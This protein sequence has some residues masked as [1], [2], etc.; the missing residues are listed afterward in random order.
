M[1]FFDR[2]RNFADKVIGRAPRAAEPGIEPEISQAWSDA[3][4]SRER[5]P[6]LFERVR[7]GAK[8][9]FNLG[10]MKEQAPPKV[11]EQKPDI[12]P[13]TPT[14]R[15]FK[16]LDESQRKDEIF[17]FRRNTQ[18]EGHAFYRLT[19]SIWDDPSIPANQRDAA[20]RKYFEEKYGITDMNEIYDLVLDRNKELIE[21]YRNAPNADKYEVLKNIKINSV[22]L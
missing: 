19:Q 18:D 20:I 15:H 4:K 1:G 13:Q 11:P 14:P 17:R 6:S 8:N 21:Q 9:L 22:E 2:L 12:T 5:K 7:E 3:A 10:R 16:P